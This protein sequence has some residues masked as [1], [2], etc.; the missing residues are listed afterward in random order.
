VQLSGF[1]GRRPQPEESRW[2]ELREAQSQAL[3]TPKTGMAVSADTGGEHEM[4]PADK[5]DAGH[6]LA[7]LAESQVY[8][9]SGR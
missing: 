6:R 3:A 5:Q 7:L 4:H 1:L 2:A 9:K 8:G